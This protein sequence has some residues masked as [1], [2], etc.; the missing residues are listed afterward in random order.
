MAKCYLPGQDLDTPGYQ[1]FQHEKCQSVDTE[2]NTGQSSALRDQY[3]ADDA[4]PGIFKVCGIGNLHEEDNGAYSTEQCLVRN[5]SNELLVTRSEIYVSVSCCQLTDDTGFLGRSME[6][7]ISVDKKIDT[8]SHATYC[9]QSTNQKSSLERSPSWAK[10]KL[11]LSHTSCKQRCDHGFLQKA[12]DVSIGTSQDKQVQNSDTIFGTQ[13]M[14]SPTFSDLELASRITIGVSNHH[15]I[16]DIPNAIIRK[17]NLNQDKIVKVGSYCQSASVEML[18]KELKGIPP[19]LTFSD[20]SPSTRKAEVVENNDSIAGSLLKKES[21]VNNLE[22]EHPSQDDIII[23]VNDSTNGNKRAMEST[24]LVGCYEHPIPVLSLRLSVRGKDVHLCVVCGLLQEKERILFMYKVVI[25]EAS[26]NYSCLLGYTRVILPDGEACFEIKSAFDKYGIQLTPDGHNLVLLECIR[27]Q[28]LREP[29][30]NCLRSK[31]I[32]LGQC[33]GHGV[34]LVSVKDGHV[35][36]LAQLSSM[37]S[38]YCILVSAPQY[39]IG[40]GENGRIRV[41]KMDLRWRMCVEEF[42]LPTDGCT[43]ANIW[44]LLA[45]PNLSHLIIGH[46]CNGYYAIWDI[47]RRVMLSAFC[48]MDYNI[49]QSVV[50][51]VVSQ[52]GC[53]KMNKNFTD[54]KLPDEVG[55]T[56]D[57]KDNIFNNI[58]PGEHQESRLRINHACSH[59]DFNEENI[60]V[61]LLVLVTPPDIDK[62]Q[63][64]QDENCDELKKKG[65]WRFALLED[66]VLLLGDTLDAR[67]SVASVLSQNGVIG[68]SD[69]H[70]YTWEVMNGRKLFTSKDFEG[71]SI[72]CISADPTSTAFAVAG[73]DNRVLLYVQ[74]TES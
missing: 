35:S 46:N 5:F 23:N 30:V 3:C 54:C 69:G 42:I 28:D 20:V 41:W 49:F 27:I 43:T 33:E 31:C 52:C 32:S 26:C 8:E 71:V 14:I 12:L 9:W 63:I 16:F 36:V 53:G 34:K 60:A 39:I 62:I 55:Y 21:D 72:S 25:G 6:G 1:I 4:Q 24:E 40:A 47:S 65:S 67:A 74:L 13:H 17:S 50:L 64:N 29:G 38:M 45:V 51:G 2:Y 73:S 10:A 15:G 57:F 22:P 70:I 18:N 56:D 7:C 37:E 48:S 68:T 66:K 61:C 11:P 19:V 59:L 58:V 44:E